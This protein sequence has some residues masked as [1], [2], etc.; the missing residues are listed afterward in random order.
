MDILK[1]SNLGL[2]FLLE[3]CAL[4]ALGYWGVRAGQTLPL[5]IALG[6]GA[7]LLLAVFWG[8]F[9]A[10]KAAIRLPRAATFLLGLLI[11]ELVALVLG[12]A[13]QSGLA[14]AYAVVIALNAGLMLAWKQ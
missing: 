2:R 10:P 6:I 3:L 12:L 8:T 9:V 11:L 7:P 4:A 13:G 14:I 5:K 1:A